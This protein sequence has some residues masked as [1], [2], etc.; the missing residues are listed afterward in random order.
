MVG[1]ARR[2]CVTWPPGI[3]VLERAGPRPKA[4]PC[5]APRAARPVPGEA[6]FDADHDV[7]PVGGKRLEKGPGGCLQIP[8]PPALAVLLQ[9]AAGHGPGLPGEAT[10]TLVRLGGDSPEVSASAVGR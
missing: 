5:C 7:L 9:E 10:V 8:R 1:A 3:A 2:A 6:A 4:R